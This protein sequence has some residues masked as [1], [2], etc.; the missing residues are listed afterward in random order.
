MQQYFDGTIVLKWDEDHV[1]MTRFLKHL[2]VISKNITP[3]VKWTYDGDTE[4]MV[5]DKAGVKNINSSV[6]FVS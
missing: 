1:K 3:D 6:M 5:D 4:D 2:I